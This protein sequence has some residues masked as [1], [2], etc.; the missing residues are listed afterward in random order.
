MVET[1]TDFL[2][3]RVSPELA[4]FI[5][6]MLPIFELRGGLIAASILNVPWGTAAVVCILGN[7]LPIP[8]ILMFVRAVLNWMMNTKTFKK[9]AKKYEAKGAK[10]AAEILEKYPA[11]LMWALYVFVA[12]PLPMTGAWTGSLAASFLNLPMKR[13]FPAI[14]AGV[15]TAAAVMLIIAYLAPS[16]LGFK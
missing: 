4:I 1:V 11:R 2:Q 14:A 9:I 15:C 6:S 7:L 12:I 5:I 3:N 16:L 8:F 13:S 10:A